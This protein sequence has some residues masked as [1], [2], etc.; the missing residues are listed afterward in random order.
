MSA[1]TIIVDNDRSYPII[2]AKPS[3]GRSI[4]QANRNGAFR[5]VFDRLIPDILPGD[6]GER[7]IFIKKGGPSKQVNRSYRRWCA[8]V[9]AGLGE[10]KWR[11]LH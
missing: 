10:N 4:F 11:S 2:F 5:P 1:I 8:L 7:K 6:L 9:S 3:S